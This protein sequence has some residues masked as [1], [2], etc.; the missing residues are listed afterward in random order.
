MTL[1]WPPQGRCLYL[2][3][4]PRLDGWRFCCAPV[5]PGKPYCGEHYARAHVV[6]PPAVKP[7]RAKVSTIALR[8][9]VSRNLLAE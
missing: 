3:G 2:H 7:V 6:G 8:A 1:T 4:D 9:G 5:V